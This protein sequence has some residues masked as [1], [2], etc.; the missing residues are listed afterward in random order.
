MLYKQY[1]CSSGSRTHTRTHHCIWCIPAICCRNHY[2]CYYIIVLFY[3][4]FCSIASILCIHSTATIF[5]VDCSVFRTVLMK[6]DLRKFPSFWF[7]FFPVFFVGFFCSAWKSRFSPCNS[8]KHKDFI[9]FALQ[10]IFYSEF[11][12]VSA[13]V[14]CAFANSFGDLN[15]GIKCSK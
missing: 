4:S 6:T 11:F 3:Y 9:S 12:T 15:S 10:W 8:E 1:E 7:K 14:F 2:Y 13:S 5:N